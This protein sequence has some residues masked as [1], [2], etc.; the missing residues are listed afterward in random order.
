M[1]EISNITIIAGQGA[2]TYS[3]GDYVNGLVIKSIVDC[4]VEYPDSTQ[5]GY[6]CLS[7]DNGKEFREHVLVEV[8]NVPVVVE[9]KEGGKTL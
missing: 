9:Y 5:I 1:R 6:R 3:L 2:N 4:S 7:S 8:W